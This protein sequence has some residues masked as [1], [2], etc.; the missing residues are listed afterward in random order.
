MR[1]IIKAIVKEILSDKTYKVESKDGTVLIATLSS[2]ASRYLSYDIY[3]G[4]EIAIEVSPYDE[5]RGRI[6]PRF[7]KRPPLSS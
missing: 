6:D 2:K 1:N 5:T 3:V 4:E 7:W